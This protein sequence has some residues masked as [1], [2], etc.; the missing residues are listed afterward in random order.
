MSK[1]SPVLAKE[2]EFG[3]PIPVLESKVCVGGCVLVTLNL[4]RW[5]QD[6]RDSQASQSNQLMFRE[7]H[8]IKN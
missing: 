2:P 4:G 1:M 7:E 5:T 6:T 8:S 3:S